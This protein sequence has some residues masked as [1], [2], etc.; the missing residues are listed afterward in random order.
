VPGLEAAGQGEAAAGAGGQRVQARTGRVGL[1]GQHGPALLAGHIAQ[2]GEQG[3]PDATAAGAR[4]YAQ[5][6]VGE[7]GIV[8]ARQ[9]EQRRADALGL[10]PGAVRAAV[11]VRVAQV[12]AQGGQHGLT[13]DDDGGD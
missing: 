6:E 12:A 7:V 5:L 11:A 9:V 13:L 8:A 2:V 4:R 1:G 3:A 10:V